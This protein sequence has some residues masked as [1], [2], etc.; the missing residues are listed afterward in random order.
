MGCQRTNPAPDTGLEI[1]RT[2]VGAY[3]ATLEEAALA[4]FQRYYEL[5]AEHGSHVNLTAVRD[6]EGIQRRHFL[7]SLAV[8]V[9][10]RSAGLL[11]GN[12]RLLDIGS[13]AGLPGIPLAI[14][15]PA[16]RVTLLEA[17]GKKA[18]FLQ[19]AVETLALQHVE[20]VNARA[21]EAAHL[22][23][24]R[25]RFDL[26]VARAVAPLETLVELA[27]PFARVGGCLAALKGSR[28][29][30][31]LRRA[32]AAIRRTG[33]GEPRRIPLPAAEDAAPL[34]LVV[35]PKLRPTPRDLPRR[36]GLPS[37]QPLR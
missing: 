9:A 18:R 17:T 8:G 30:E 21:E 11:R 7:E 5:L 6:Y 33:G 14:A 29:A 35:V 20:V 10:L 24:L 12:E 34:S 37:S 13:G 2:G 4:A 15:W 3:S 32:P 1:L 31:E 23:A 36:P 28:A 26:V 16:L 25:E 22:P 19:L 27:L